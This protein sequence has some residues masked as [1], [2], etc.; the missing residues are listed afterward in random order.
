MSAVYVCGKGSIPY[1]RVQIQ[2]MPV[3]QYEGLGLFDVAVKSFLVW[4]IGSNAPW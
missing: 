3:V 1:P 2:F 4:S